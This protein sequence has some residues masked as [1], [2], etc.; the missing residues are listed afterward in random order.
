[1]KVVQKSQI[2]GANMKFKLIIICIFCILCF[3]VS[4][5]E[6]SFQGNLN[7]AEN[8]NV[9]GMLTAAEVNITTNDSLY[10][11]F[12]RIDNEGPHVAF[13]SDL[14]VYLN[15]EPTTYLSIT[16]H[17]GSAFSHANLVLRAGGL[18][19][20]SIFNYLKNGP[21]HPYSPNAS[22]MIN[23]GGSHGNF[24]E[25]GFQFSWWTIYNLLKD[26]DGNVLWLNLS[27]NMMTLDET[28]LWVNGT[29]ELIADSN[30]QSLRFYENSGEEYINLKLD[31]DG[32]LN[33]Y[34]DSGDSRL[35]IPDSNQQSNHAYR[36]IG[37]NA[38]YHLYGD[39]TDTTINFGDDVI[40]FYAG[41]DNYAQFRNYERIG[42][43]SFIAF[44]YLNND[45]DFR[46]DSDT[47]DDAVFFEGSSGRVGIGTNTPVSL[48]DVRGRITADNIN[49]TE[50][51]N[52]VGDLKIQP[53]AQG[54]V[55]LFG[56]TDVGDSDH[57]KEL[58]VC[59]KA[60]EGDNC[61]EFYI[62]ASE[63]GMIHTDSDM[64]LQ[65]QNAFTINSV[66]SNIFLKLGDSAGAKEVRIR[67][68]SGMD[69]STIDSNGNAW[70]RGDMEIGVS[71]DVLIQANGPSYFNGGDFSVNNSDLF[72]DVSEGYVGI[73]TASPEALLHI[74][75]DAHLRLTSTGNDQA[76]ISLNTPSSIHQTFVGA[77]GA[78]GE[79]L[80]GT[81]A[82]DFA[83]G[84]RTGGAIRISADSGFQASEGINLLEN[85]NVGI[86]T[87]SPGTKLDVNGSVNV[88]G[89]YYGDGSQLTGIEPL[90]SGNYS[91][92]AFI[93][94]ANIFGA[95]DQIF[96]SYTLFIDSTNNRI[97][98]GTNDPR[99]E[100]HLNSTH[101]RI[102]LEE[103]DAASN[104]KVWEI[105]VMNEEF[106]I[107]TA[108]D[109]HTGSQTAMRIGGRSGTSITEVEFPHGDVTIADLS[110]SGN[111]YA[112]LDSTGKLFRSN[113]AC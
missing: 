87:T 95:F 83:I 50:I 41:G 11:G 1:M 51:S 45:V 26:E 32:D 43:Q 10:M 73:G 35:E 42:W 93:N 49:T 25:E 19:M 31:S 14:D 68:K 15:N 65:G 7:V 113:T 29:V 54:N 111:D 53:D 98:I 21:D 33:F 79:I 22:G 6:S 40:T 91:N 27:K 88:S 4:A 38:L 96:D 2:W 55:E 81:E 64:T 44:N 37:V 75:G 103:S 99:E 112:C 86:G 101:P 77:I 12:L 84:L 3:N 17:N 80:T 60:P 94:K 46:W 76:Y 92:V 63:K 58:R 90:W 56:D 34:A 70:F 82:G 66:D 8:L 59:R 71:S 105:G 69:V 13:R 108:N 24:I 52:R 61:M 20:D 104:E 106:T 36:G 28:G 102:A 23:E 89:Y 16:N 107:T 74:E 48:L 39:D 30:N 110:G 67:D 97:G 5:M 18:V 9:N 100:L 109:I 85:G 47:I 78:G 62:T 57:G 72:V